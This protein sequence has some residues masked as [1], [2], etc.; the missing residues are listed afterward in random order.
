MLREYVTTELKR[1]SLEKDDSGSFEKVNEAEVLESMQ[2]EK[3]S[4]DGTASPPQTDIAAE[5]EEEAEVPTTADSEKVLDDDD[6]PSKNPRVDSF[7]KKGQRAVDDFRDWCRIIRLDAV[8]MNAEWVP[9]SAVQANVTEEE[10]D[11]RANDVGIQDHGHLEASRTH[12]AA[13]LV[14]ILEAYALYDPETGYC[15]GMSDLL[16]PFVAL[17]ESDSQAFWCYVQFMKRAKDNFRMDET[18]IRRQLQLVAKIFSVADP[19]F[20]DHLL[21]I[22]AEDCF[23]VYRMIVVLLRR[24]LTFEQTVCL[25]EV[26]WADWAAL[27]L[28]GN[29]KKLPDGF[30]G[31]RKLPASDDFLLFTIAAAVLQQRRFIIERCRGVDEILRECNAMAGKLDIWELM[32]FGRELLRDYQQKVGHQKTD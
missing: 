4:T 12:H 31:R 29:S 10:A 3:S 2:E 18:G 32:D 8:R 24:E 30:D 14:A 7:L 25:W 9:Y 28:K 16:S 19:Q 23:F 22:Q 6:E 26:I 1:R 5:E 11:R 17:M 21:K 15:Q 20:Y 13:R 27:R